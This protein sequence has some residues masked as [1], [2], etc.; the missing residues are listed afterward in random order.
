[1]KIYWN[2]LE[3]DMMKIYNSPAKGSREQHRKEGDG[4]G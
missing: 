4:Y 1:M 2:Q 3:T